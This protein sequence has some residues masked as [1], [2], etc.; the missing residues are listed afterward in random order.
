MSQP[1]RSFFG[2]LFCRH[3]WNE[4]PLQKEFTGIEEMTHNLPNAIYRKWVCEKCGKII[5]IKQ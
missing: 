1:P 3:V 4:L 2:Q 5:K